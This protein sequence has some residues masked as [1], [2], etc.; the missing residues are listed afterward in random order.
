MMNK[1]NWLYALL[2]GGLCAVVLNSE[3]L[4]LGGT[5]VARTYLSIT[6]DIDYFLNKRQFLIAVKQL[7]V[8]FVF[9]FIYGTGIRKRYTI[10]SYIRLE[11]KK[12]WLM[13]Q[14]LWLWKDAFLFF[15]A[16]TAITLGICAAACQKM[17]ILSDYRLVLLSL[18]AFSYMGSLFTG[19][20]NAFSF[21]IKPKNA[22]ISGYIIMLI[23][24]FASMAVS[25]FLGQ[26]PYLMYLNPVT[27]MSLT[28]S[29]EAKL[30]IGGAGSCILIYIIISGIFTY[31]CHKTEYV[32]EK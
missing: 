30:V 14:F 11:K 9:C 24:A 16:Y 32:W 21:F 18:F 29:M 27:T 22:M 1:L 17:P 2:L 5:V 23:N 10:Y 19:L 13:K 6:F 4:F 26:H 20:V 28:E 12:L 3:P 8:M 7:F 31:V 25:G 15:G